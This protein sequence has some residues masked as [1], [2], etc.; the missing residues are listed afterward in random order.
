MAV[1]YGTSGNDEIF[2]KVFGSSNKSVTI[3]AREGDDRVVGGTKSD[4]IYGEAG[5]DELDGGAGDDKL[6]GGAGDDTLIGGRGSDRIDGGE[7]Y[8]TANYLSS[9]VGAE[10][11][12]A[13]GYAKQ[14]EGST[15]ASDKL[16]SIEAAEGTNFDDMIIGDSNNNTLSSHDGNDKIYGG[17]GDDRMWGHDGNDTISGGNGNDG[18]NGGNG[19]DV[20]LGGAGD[21]KISGGATGKDSIE[22]N[23]G[24]DRLSIN[25]DDTA[26][27]GAGADT[28]VITRFLE[29]G[30]EINMVIEDFVDGEDKIDLSE[31]GFEKFG[32]ELKFE[33][34]SFDVNSNST[35]I[36][37][38]TDDLKTGVQINLSGYGKEEFSL[39]TEAD[40]IFLT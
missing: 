6:Y 15:A 14:L 9:L 25:A 27:G 2:G 17:S 28:F 23:H 21:D 5:N 7:G 12:L 37:I 36:S 18:M 22:G 20:L 16:F 1:I 3:Y 26:K 8:D 4:K 19:D 30:W 13:S 39:L 40:F 10:I 24:N 29:I 34:L 35:L 11:N 32:L 31:L 33:D 38:S